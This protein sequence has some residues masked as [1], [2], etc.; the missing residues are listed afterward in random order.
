MRQR[1]KEANIPNRYCGRCGRK[2]IRVTVPAEKI[3]KMI[4]YRS[5]HPYD[6]YNPETGLRQYA[7]YWKCPKQWLWFHDEY[8]NEAHLVT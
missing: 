2:L 7:R 8:E 1:K 6:K 5:F 3:T 4:M